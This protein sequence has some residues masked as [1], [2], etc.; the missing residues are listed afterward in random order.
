MNLTIRF[1]AAC[2]YQLSKLVHVYLQVRKENEW[3]EEK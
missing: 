2:V 1:G 3:C